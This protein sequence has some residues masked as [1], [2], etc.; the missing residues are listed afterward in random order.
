MKVYVAMVFDRH[1]DPEP[2]VFS[3]AEAAIAFARQEFAECVHSPEHIVKEPVEGWLWHARYEL[4][5][6]SAWVIEKE[7]DRADD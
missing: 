1:A 7:L 3:T 6:D 4:E 5:D 2:Y